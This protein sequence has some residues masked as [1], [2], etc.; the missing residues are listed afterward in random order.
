MRFRGSNNKIIFS[1]SKAPRAVFGENMASLFSI[2]GI[3]EEM[4][5]YYTDKAIFGFFE[6]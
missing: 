3:F 1:F 4:V 6:Y 2:I 5:G